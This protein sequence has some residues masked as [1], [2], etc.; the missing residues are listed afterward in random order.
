MLDEVQRACKWAFRERKMQLSLTQGLSYGQSDWK[1]KSG[2]AVG[3][4]GYTIQHTSPSVSGCLTAEVGKESVAE[5]CLKKK[6]KG[7]FL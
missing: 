6:L 5:I 1:Q 2:P 7:D 3:P 4:M